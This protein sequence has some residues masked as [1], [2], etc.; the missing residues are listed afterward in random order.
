MKQKIDYYKKSWGDLNDLPQFKKNKTKI[1]MC[2][3]TNPAFDLS[4]RKFLAW[5]WGV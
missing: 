4:D 5:S 1:E 2:I 3:I